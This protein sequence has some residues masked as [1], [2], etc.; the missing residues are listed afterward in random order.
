MNI[1]RYTD[2]AQS[3]LQAAQTLAL[4]KGHQKLLPQH[5]LSAMLSDK[6]AL[7]EKIITLCDGNLDLLKAELESELRKIPQVAG[8]GAG[9]LSISQ[10]MARILLLAEKIA[11]KN[12]DQFVAIETFLQ[13]ILDS[14]ELS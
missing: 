5:F 4:S 14:P 2:K 3:L 6:D 7:V 9:N 11:D 10:E 1:E 12:S 8:S 13:A